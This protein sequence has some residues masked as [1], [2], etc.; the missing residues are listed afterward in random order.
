ME[1]DD[2][3]DMF[4]LAVLQNQAKSI[5]GPKG[6]M[7]HTEQFAPGMMKNLGLNFNTLAAT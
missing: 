1:S 7:N 4:D 3:D 5:H 2:D 6:A